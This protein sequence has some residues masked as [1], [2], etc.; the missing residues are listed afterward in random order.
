MYIYL[1]DLY[2]EIHMDGLTYVC[3]FQRGRKDYF[4]FLGLISTVVSYLMP[5][6]SL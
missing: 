1:R 2:K 5:K 3:V 4:L 6:P